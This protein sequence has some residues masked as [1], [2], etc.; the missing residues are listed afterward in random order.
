MEP[1]RAA[2][3]STPPWVAKRA[4]WLMFVGFLGIYLAVG[5]VLNTTHLRRTG[6]VLFGS[7]QG[8]VQR[9]V[10]VFEASHY[11]TEAHPLFVLMMNPLGSG[12]KAVTGGAFAKWLNDDNRT[13]LVASLLNAT[14]GAATIGLF[15]AVLLRAGLPLGLATGFTLVLGLS[16]AHLFWGAIVETHTFASTSLAVLLLLVSWPTSR[17]GFYALAGVMAFGVNATSL[18]HAVIAQAAA[19]VRWDRAGVAA[20]AARSF[21]LI[22][23][24]LG[25]GAVLS[26]VQKAVY[27]STG[28]F[29]MP[30]TASKEMSYVE[31]PVSAKGGLAR[32]W[33]IVKHQLAFNLMAPRLEVIREGYQ[34]ERPMITF[35]TTLARAWSAPGWISLAL[36]GAVLGWGLKGV[37]ILRHRLAMAM[38]GSVL[39]NLAL[40]SVYGPLSEQ[41]L[42]APNTTLYVVGLAAMLLHEAT[43]RASPRGAQVA[44]GLTLALAAGEA[45]ANALF[46]VDV[47]R[48]YK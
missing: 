37:A 7:D 32:P 21:A 22:V 34:P 39:F 45:V 42:Y 24:I 23:V 12:I 46:L 47:Y 4:P 25:V 3:F 38:V 16:S 18:A 43:R 17:F 8:R 31:K 40:F 28:L 44:V 30:E 2:P 14:A 13:M 6:D 48:V 15:M 5:V 36:W 29:F 26:L 35:Q 9:D 27:P 20:C 33:E 41:F 1:V 10:A 19:I 11:R